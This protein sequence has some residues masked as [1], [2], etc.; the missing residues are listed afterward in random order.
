MYLPP[1]NESI[2]NHLR[3]NDY[4]WKPSYVRT[5]NFEPTVQAYRKR[6]RGE[7]DKNK[8]KLDWIRIYKIWHKNQY[9]KNQMKR[10]ANQNMIRL[11]QKHRQLISN[12]R[13]VEKQLANKGVKM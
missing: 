11:L 9:N 4:R 6:Y 3:S 13:N 8:V 1:S 5:H 12:L 2:L 10:V 7:H